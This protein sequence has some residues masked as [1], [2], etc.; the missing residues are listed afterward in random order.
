MWA[1]APTAAPEFAILERYA[2]RVASEITFETFKTVIWGRSAV[3][4]CRDVRAHLLEC[5]TAQT[6]YTHLVT[7]SDVAFLPDLI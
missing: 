4:I 7:L 5:G 3:T 1:S 6:Q 2:D